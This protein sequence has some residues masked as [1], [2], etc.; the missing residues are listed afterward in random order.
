M[1]GGR[2]KKMPKRIPLTGRHKMMSVKSL[3]PTVNLK[4]LTTIDLYIAPASHI[5]IEHA[6]FLVKKIM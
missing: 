3:Y 6:A 2:K 5:A 4:S 1:L